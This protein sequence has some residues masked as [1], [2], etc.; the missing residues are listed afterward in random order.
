MRVSSCSTGWTSILDN[1][2]YIIILQPYCRNVSDCSKH[3][4]TTVNSGMSLSYMSSR[5]G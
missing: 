4:V 1:N 5:G 3:I 2:S